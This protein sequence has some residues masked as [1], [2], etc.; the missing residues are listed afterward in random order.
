MTVIVII[1]AV[2]NTENT[3]VEV[4][5]AEYRAPLV[6]IILTAAIAGVV[7]DEIFG[8]C[9]RHAVVGGLPIERAPAPSPRP[10]TLRD[11][12]TT[13]A[14]GVQLRHGCPAALRRRRGH[15]PVAMAR[16]QRDGDDEHDTA[17]R[18]SLGVP[19]RVAAIIWTGSNDA[20]SVRLGLDV[21]P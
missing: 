8:L 20:R 14:F 5:R 16:R 12:C 4:F 10:L 9:W 7:L 15:V 18:L 19:D 2:Q 17:S 21:G 13:P 3:T 11:V 6:A 1:L